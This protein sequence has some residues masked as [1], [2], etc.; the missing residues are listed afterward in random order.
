LDDHDLGVGWP[1]LWHSLLKQRSRAAVELELVKTPSHVA[2]TGEFVEPA[3]DARARTPEF[4][5]S[6]DALRSSSKSLTSEAS[7]DVR[8]DPHTAQLPQKDAEGSF[9]MNHAI[10]AKLGA[11]KIWVSFSI[12]FDGG[13]HFR[14]RASTQEPFER[15]YENTQKL[16]LRWTDSRGKVK[17]DLVEIQHLNPA[18]PTAR[19]RQ[20]VVLTGDHQGELVVVDSYSRTAKTLVVASLSDAEKRWVEKEENVCWVEPF[21]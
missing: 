11:R 5:D 2:E 21:V 6:S 13:R 9:L 16:N 14:R 1:E 17:R 4:D 20:G 3:W 12:S 10:W 18:A 8:F 19:N 15:C 7:S